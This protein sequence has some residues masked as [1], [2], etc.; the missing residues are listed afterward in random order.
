M[1]DDQTLAAACIDVMAG[2][3]VIETL[4]AFADSLVQAGRPD[5]ALDVMVRV[6]THVEG[7]TKILAVALWGDDTKAP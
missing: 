4:G 5:E 3:R 7:L 2:A 1:K 6:Q